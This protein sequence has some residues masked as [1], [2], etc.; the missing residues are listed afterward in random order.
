MKRQILASILGI[1]AA[2]ALNS[3]HAQGT[4]SLDNYDGYGAKIVYGTGVPGGT[5]GN[6]VVNNTPAG[7]TWTI[8]LYY[9]LGNVTGSVSSD[10]TGTAD[11]ST[12]GGGLA[13]LSG[14]P[15]DTTTFNESSDPGTFITSA[16]AI[17]PGYSSGVVTF[18]VVSY[19]GANYDAS[20]YRGHSSAFTL[21]PATGTATA[22]YISSGTAVSLGSLGG[23]QQFSASPV[24]EPSILALSGIGAAALMLIRR[25][26]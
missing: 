4:V 10:P 18:E 20:T 11:P 7:V 8:G 3:A 15:G 13:F 17:I 14:N 22:P 6:G 24:P 16:N 23:M 5:T 2:M 25:K 9:A 12:L 19:S 1:A 21:T 26:K